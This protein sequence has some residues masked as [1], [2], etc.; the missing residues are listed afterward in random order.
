MEDRILCLQNVSDAKLA[1]I[2]RGAIA[3]VFASLREGFGLPIVEAMACGC[4]VITSSF[5]A[6]K[7]VGG[8]ASLFVN[9][10]DIE[11]IREKMELVAS[12]NSLRQALKKLGIERAANFTW[13]K[14][15]ASVK[16]VIL[17]SR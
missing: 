5:G 17:M 10:K 9:P 8:S 2:Y 7:E 1:E 4:P 12:D 15:T 11:E 13:E 16:D 3:L 14:T 6:M